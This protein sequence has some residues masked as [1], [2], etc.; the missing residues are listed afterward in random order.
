MAQSP[1]YVH[2]CSLTFTTKIENCSATESCVQYMPVW[3][4][5][6]TRPWPMSS[7]TGQVSYSMYPEVHS[8]NTAREVE[9][10]NETGHTNTR[11]L[12]SQFSTNRDVFWRKS[13]RK[14]WH[15]EMENGWKISRETDD[16]QSCCSDVTVVWV[17]YFRFVW[18]GTVL[19]H[20]LWI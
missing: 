20:R 5:H 6:K 18:M 8:A 15:E 19:T 2:L 14:G 13:E 1:R 7:D 17:W 11:E 12:M 9:E 3:I 16:R 10:T 4:T